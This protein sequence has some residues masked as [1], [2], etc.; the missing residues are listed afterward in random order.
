MTASLDDRSLPLVVV[1]PHADDAFLSLGAHI[2]RWVREKRDVTILTVFSGTRKRGLDAQA[3]AKAVRVHWL[4]CGLVEGE[5]LPSDLVP[6]KYVPSHA[7]LILPAGITHP[8][9]IA[10][11]DLWAGYSDWRYL[12]QPYAITQSN[13]SEVTR[14][15]RPS[16]VESYLKP[17][18]R[19]FKFIP[20][21]KDQAKF[22]HF[23]PAEKLIQGVE[24]ILRR[25]PGE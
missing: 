19:K 6:G 16:R 23:N 17:G 24:M 22:F 5:P 18:V 13:G 15:L 2:Q 14:L 1:E 9:H 7:Q 8:E 11:R 20:L 25:S 21:F 3:Y 10:V 4:G 12:D